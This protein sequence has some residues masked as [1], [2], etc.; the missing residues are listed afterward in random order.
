VQKMG[1]PTSTFTDMAMSCQP[2]TSIHLM[3]N[4]YL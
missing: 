3:K 4:P 1:V 2:S